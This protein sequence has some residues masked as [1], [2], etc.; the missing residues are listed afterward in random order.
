MNARF[1]SAESNGPNLLVAVVVPLGVWALPGQI[2]LVD[3]YP[4]GSLTALFCSSLCQ[5]QIFSFSI[6]GSSTG[7]GCRAFPRASLI[8]CPLTFS[9]KLESY[10]NVCTEY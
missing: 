6:G 4:S 2:V 9:H 5:R 10:D 8:M 3:L 1:C 7:E